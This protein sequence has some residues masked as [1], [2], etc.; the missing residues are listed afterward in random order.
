[1]LVAWTLIQSAMNYH[2][3][4]VPFLY[5]ID[6]IAQKTLLLRENSPRGC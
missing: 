1:M 6:D 2:P 5:R 4:A 3:M